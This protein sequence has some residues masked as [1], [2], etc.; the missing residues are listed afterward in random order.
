MFNLR[1]LTLTIV[2]NS[3]GIKA[4]E[5]ICEVHQYSIDFELIDYDKTV[6][7]LIAS[8]EIIELEYTLPTLP[9]QI[10]SIYFPKGTLLRKL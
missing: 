6:Q 9:Y 5:L 3:S 4:T 7:E 10:K 1:D 2:S 8:G